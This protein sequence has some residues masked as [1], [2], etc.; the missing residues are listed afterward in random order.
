[1][2]EECMMARLDADVAKARVMED[3]MMT[4]FTSIKEALAA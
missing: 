4:H 3:C 2:R 1:M